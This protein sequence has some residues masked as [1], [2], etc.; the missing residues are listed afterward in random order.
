MATPLL[1]YFGCGAVL[2]D[3]SFNTPAIQLD[4]S[5]GVYPEFIIL[6]LTLLI[7]SGVLKEA[8]KIHD[9]HRLTI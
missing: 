1:Q 2:K 7:L 6:G 9:E 8:V 4:P 5:F 3:I